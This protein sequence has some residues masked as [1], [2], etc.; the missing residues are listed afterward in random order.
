MYDG[1]TTINNEIQNSCRFAVGREGGGVGGLVV[2]NKIG[3]AGMSYFTTKSGEGRAVEAK[4]SG[5]TNVITGPQIAIC[6]TYRY[7]FTHRTA[8]L[9]GKRKFIVIPI[10]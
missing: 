2:Y 7:T 1:L 5:L 4:N 8:V 6:I 9:V 10:R 3:E